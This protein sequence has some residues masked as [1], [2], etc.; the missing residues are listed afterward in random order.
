MMPR[1]Q[2][3]KLKAQCILNQPTPVMLLKESV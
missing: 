2:R 1:A 3:S